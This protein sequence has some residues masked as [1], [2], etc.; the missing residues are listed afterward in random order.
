MVNCFVVQ[1]ATLPKLAE[2]LPE[3]LWHLTFPAAAPSG[4]NGETVEHQA[5]ISVVPQSPKM[6][7]EVKPSGAS[8]FD[9]LCLAADSQSAHLLGFNKC[10][11]PGAH[12]TS[13]TC[14]VVVWLLVLCLNELLTPQVNVCA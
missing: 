9:C 14:I 8:C 12:G 13:S 5:A 4:S 11:E 1:G 2:R 7:T 10:F 3:L 6:A